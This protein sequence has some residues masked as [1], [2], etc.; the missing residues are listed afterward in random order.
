MRTINSQNWILRPILLRSNT[1]ILRATA[2][3]LEGAVVKESGALIAKI[4]Q[5]IYFSNRLRAEKGK[6]QRAGRP[7]R[8]TTS[9]PPLDVGREGVVA[10][11][12]KRLD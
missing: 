2:P 8:T 6:E 11:L 12:A 3:G 10:F 1:N 4:A 5:I 9:G 7:G